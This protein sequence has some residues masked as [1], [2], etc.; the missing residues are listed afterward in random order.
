MGIDPG[1]TLGYAVLDIDGKLIAANSSKQLNL[2]S[3]ISEVVDLGKV[4]VI[5]TDKAKIPSLVNLFSAKTGGRIIKPKEDLRISEKKKIIIGYK[6]ENEHQEDA[7]ASALFA[8]KEIRGLLKKINIFAENSKNFSIK[9]RIIELVLTKNISIRHAIGIIESP[10]KV[11]L[12]KVKKVAEERML[13]S[14]DFLKL[15]NKVKRYEKE[16]LFL[17]MQN[18]NLNI[19]LKE[20]SDRYDY[21]SKKNSWV[22]SDENAEKLIG[23]KES[24]IKFFDKEIKSKDEEINLLRDKI[25]NLNFILSR[26]NEAYLLKKLDNLGS[27]E[28]ENKN[29]FL[30]IKDKDILLIN[31]PNI[32]NNK[33]IEK[34]S[35]KV[36]VIIYKDSLSKTTERLPFIFVERKNLK[37]TEM[38]YFA[39]VGKDEL[40]KEISKI[41]ILSKI[42][43]DY[44]EARITN[45]YN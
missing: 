10:E 17:K 30:N 6:L 36:R 19:K 8:Y 28:F 43:E 39:I 3:L 33:V 45:L 32:F 14:E 41:N 2:N 4:I 5:G 31:N 21:M 13:S 23:F 20:I 15:R 35:D 1:T 16:I 22:K 11:N 27:L 37:L 26:L 34:L 9:D 12:E 29:K 38:E 44:K 42:I 7:L 18:N 24:R 25:N 40:N